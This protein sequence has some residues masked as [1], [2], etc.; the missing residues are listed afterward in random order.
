MHDINESSFLKEKVNYAAEMT[1]RNVKEYHL[2]D[3]AEMSQLLESIKTVR[4][5]LISFNKDMQSKDFFRSRHVIDIYNTE[6]MF[7]VS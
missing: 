5:N 1:H 3:A 4:K 7:H 2:R 6:N